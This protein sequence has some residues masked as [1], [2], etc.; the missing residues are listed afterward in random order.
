MYTPA[1]RLLAALRPQQETDETDGFVVP[2]TTRLRS[3]A[4]FYGF[5]CSAAERNLSLGDYM[6][7][8]CG[9][10]P[11][12]GRG[13]AWERAE[14]VITEIEGRAI[15]KIRLRI[16]P[17]RDRRTLPDIEAGSTP[18]RRVQDWEAGAS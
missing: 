9:G 14:L 2:A 11:Q 12:V 4:G 3:L 16:L 15:S 18:K 10:R 1:A 5:K 17:L 7:R 8:L 13:T 6:K